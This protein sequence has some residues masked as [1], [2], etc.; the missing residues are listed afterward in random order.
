MRR[1]RRRY[2]DLFSLFYDPIIALHSKDKSA[3]LRRFL[4]E[5]AGIAPGQKVLD[6]CTGTGAVALMA[7]R[8]LKGNGVATGVDFSQGMLRKAREKA[9]KQGINVHFVLADVSKLPFL[10]ESFH[11][12]T[13]SHAM[14]ELDPSTREG[15]LLEAK[16]VL[17]P[18]GVFIMM[19][20]MEPSSP[21]IRFLYHIRL[22]TM[23]SPE[24][25]EFAM[26]ERP[27]L[28]RYLEDVRLEP[29]PQGRSKVVRGIKSG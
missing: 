20:H 10:N 12:V 1:W 19:E 23:G 25:R 13:C 24:N 22:A 15:A 9:R 4:L 17:V 29:A 16:R 2:Y 8:M 14:Y 28:S 3:R 26:D 7:G 5:R 18:G 27:F 6:I 11:I 21:F